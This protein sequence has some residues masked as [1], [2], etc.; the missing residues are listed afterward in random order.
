MRTEPKNTNWT[1]IEFPELIPINYKIQNDQVSLFLSMIFQ[2]ILL[3]TNN[4]LHFHPER[5]QTAF[6]H[7]LQKGKCWV[8]Q[9]RLDQVC[10][11]PESHLF[12]P[13]NDWGISSALSSKERIRD[14]QRPSDTV[15]GTSA[16]AKEE[17]K[18]IWPLSPV[19]GDVEERDPVSF[20]PEANI[21]MCMEKKSANH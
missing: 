13:W 9:D 4:G 17:M 20:R 12:L 14:G 19:K 8:T 11:H 21:P 2:L 1:P 16:C 10:V 18:N 6:S 7:S 3:Q 15:L 5:C